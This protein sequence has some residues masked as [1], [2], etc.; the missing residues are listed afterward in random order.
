MLHFEIVT[1]YLLILGQ[2]LINTLLLCCVW[3]CESPFS[4]KGKYCV[5]QTEPRTFNEGCDVRGFDAFDINLY[6]NNDIFVWLPIKSRYRYGPK[7]YQIPGCLFSEIFENKNFDEMKTSKEDCAVIKGNVM[8]YVDCSEKHPHLCIYDNSKH[9]D[10]CDNSI[11]DI[12]KCLWS[13]HN[14]TDEDELKI[15]GDVYITDSEM[16]FSRLPDPGGVN[17]SYVQLSSDCAKC[18]INGD[19]IPKADLVLNFE[20]QARKLFLTVYSPEGK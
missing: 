8:N 4:S 19:D 18:K 12:K 20:V 13:Y 5:F 10:M 11:L 7:V 15:N 1:V 14:N 9:T 3:A 17:V 16:S 2:F 6:R